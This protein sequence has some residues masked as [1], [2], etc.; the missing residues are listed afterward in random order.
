MQNDRSKLVKRLNRLS[1]LYDITVQSGKPYRI[2]KSKKL[3]INALAK[4]SS[5]YPILEFDSS[6][7]KNIFNESGRL[8][9]IISKKR[10]AVEAKEYETAASLRTMEKK[11]LR[12]LLAEIGV[13]PSDHFFIYGNNIYKIF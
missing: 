11:L 4:V 7:Y 3:F 9:S 10:E 12:S 1:K 6:T 5:E 2:S 8:I 13:N